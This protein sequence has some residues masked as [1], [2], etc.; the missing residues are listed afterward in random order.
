MSSTRSSSKAE[1]GTGRSVG[2]T[3]LELSSWNR[4]VLTLASALGGRLLHTAT[5]Q[6]RQHRDKEETATSAQEQGTD[7]HVS[8]GTRDRLSRQHRDKEQT[9]TSAQEQ[10]TDCHVSTGTRSS[11]PRQHRNKGQTGTSAQGQGADCHVSPGTRRRL[12]R[13]PRDKAETA[14]SEKGDSQDS[15]GRKR[16]QP[17][18]K[19]QAKKRTGIHFNNTSFTPQWAVPA[20]VGITTKLKNNDNKNGRTSSPV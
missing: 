13:Q 14:T 10:G 15:T 16:R 7:C 12:P 4:D 9:A 1:P 18:H 5:T 2:C 11:L 17:R 19:E 6:P 8:T 3:W 20:D